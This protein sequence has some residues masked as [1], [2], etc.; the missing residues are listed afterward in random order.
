[1]GLIQHLT[2]KTLWCRLSLLH[3]FASNFCSYCK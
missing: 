2:D 3:S 1:M